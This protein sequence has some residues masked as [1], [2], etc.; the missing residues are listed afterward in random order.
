M[1]EGEWRWIH[2]F[3]TKTLHIVIALIMVHHV[4]SC[5][6][7]SHHKAPKSLIITI[8]QKPLAK[9]DQK[10][11]AKSYHHENRLKNWTFEASVV[12]PRIKRGWTQKFNVWISPVFWQT[13]LFHVF[14]LCRKPPP[15][16]NNDGFPKSRER[17]TASSCAACVPFKVSKIILVPGERGFSAE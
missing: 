7:M 16:R 13:L 1:S 4:A 5:C 6:I 17:T 14:L 9:S 8:N 12:K 15:P 3:I 11:L 2:E 10:A